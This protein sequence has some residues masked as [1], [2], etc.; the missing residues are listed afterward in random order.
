MGRVPAEYARI[1]PCYEYIIYHDEYCTVC[2]F[3][4]R[5]TYNAAGLEAKHEGTFEGNSNLTAIS[6]A[7]VLAIII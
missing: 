6:V 4:M 1:F 3:T 7:T 5:T 2:D